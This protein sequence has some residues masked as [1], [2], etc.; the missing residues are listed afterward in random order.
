MTGWKLVSG[1]GGVIGALALGFALTHD[2]GAV[3]NGNGLTPIEELGKLLFFDDTLSTP[4]GQSCAACHAPDVGFTGPVE[5]INA[6]GSVYPGAVHTR[7]GNRKPPASSYAGD[8]PVFFLDEGEGLFL[9]G[10]FWD[11]RATGWIL[12]DPLAEQAQ[13]PFLNPLEQNN[14][15]PLHVVMRVAKSDYADLYEEVFGPLDAFQSLRPEEVE[16]LFALFG[17]TEKVAFVKGD[18]TSLVA[19]A[20][21]TPADWQ[22]QV[23]VVYENIARAIAAYERSP[24]VNP[25]DSK[26]DWYLAGMVDLTE[27]EMW[28]LELFNGE[29]QCFLCHPSEPGPGGEPPLFTDFSYDNLGLPKN[30]ANPFY[31]MPPGFNPDGAAWIDPGLGGFLANVPAY[32]HLAAE[33]WGKHK[34][35]T[36]RNVDKRPYP[37]FV[38]AFGHNGV[39]KTLEDITHFY[40]TRD[41]EAWPPP[42]V[43]MNVNTDELGDLGLTADEEAAV[44]AFLRTLSDGFVP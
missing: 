37:E 36:L 31:T 2:A 28:G 18:S 44:V 8:S 39:F 35:P 19:P 38:K 43:P 11:G 16:Q 33:N 26:Y 7:F 40:N 23:D 29:A 10:V 34:V 9:G 20:G 30:P 5:E 32:A 17:G 42:E 41:V 4:P 13:G 12:G 14:P 24:E 22:K 25:F 3:A 27:Q 6:G 1:L 15:N 21:A